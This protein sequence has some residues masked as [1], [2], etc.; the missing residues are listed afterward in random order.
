[1]KSKNKDKWLKNEENEKEM[2]IKFLNLEKNGHSK[3][4]LKH[5][6]ALLHA[7]NHIVVDIDIHKENK[8]GE[9]TN[10]TLE[11]ADYI[12]AENK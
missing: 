6:L 5:V 2:N 7:N 8:N 10:K 9:K 12:D 3:E 11:N 1:M 4:S